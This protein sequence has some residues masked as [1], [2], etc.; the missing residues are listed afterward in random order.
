M[1][2]DQTFNQHL[3]ERELD[4]DRD[5]HIAKHRSANDGPSLSSQINSL[6]VVVG[7]LCSIEPDH[8]LVPFTKLLSDSLSKEVFVCDFLSKRFHKVSVPRFSF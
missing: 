7:Q 1:R 5:L 2:Q 3:T 4:L 8:A 6:A